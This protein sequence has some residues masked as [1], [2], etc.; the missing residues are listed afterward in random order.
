MN[1][2][3][4]KV[5]GVL[6]VRVE[7]AR[8]DS[9]ISAEFK[10]EL[11]RLLEGEAVRNVLI[12]LR[13]VDYA[14]SSGLGALLFGH[15]HARGHEAALKLVHVNPKIRTLIRIAKLD[16]VLEIFDGEDEALNSF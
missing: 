7:E 8:L 4:E 2:R 14:D 11:L 15:R 9:T 5:G 6:V 3:E 13:K 16:D 10:T 12:D 1:V